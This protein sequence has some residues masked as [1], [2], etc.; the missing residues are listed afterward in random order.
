MKQNQPLKKVM[1]M[2]YFRL[3]VIKN[4]INILKT[5]VLSKNQLKILKDKQDVMQKDK[6]HGL[7]EMNA[8]IGYILIPRTIILKKH[9]NWLMN[10]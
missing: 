5:N 8:S 6:S 10:F 1:V 9:L 3:S 4:Y 7:E 2:A